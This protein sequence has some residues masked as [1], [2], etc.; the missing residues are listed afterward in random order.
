M[1]GAVAA[2][3]SVCR[4]WCAAVGGICEGGSGWQHK[5]RKA[6]LLVGQPDM[7]AEAGNTPQVHLVLKQQLQ[8]ADDTHP[9][10]RL[11]M[12][13]LPLRGAHHGAQHAGARRHRHSGR[14]CWAGGGGGCERRWRRRR[15]QRWWQG[16]AKGR[17]DCGGRAVL[18]ERSLAEEHPRFGAE[19]Q[20]L[21]VL[22]R[23]WCRYQLQ[24]P[25][26]YDAVVAAI[27]HRRAYHLL[28]QLRKH[29][30]EPTRALDG[31]RG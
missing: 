9:L 6:H 28:G 21:L 13:V 26:S 15:G 16:R 4:G 25:I 30:L 19:H 14:C 5:W 23:R 27:A 17:G 7:D 12:P 18:V 11:G 1:P 22:L 29:G 20:V 24:Q 10:S 3:T 8:I 31:R 2:C